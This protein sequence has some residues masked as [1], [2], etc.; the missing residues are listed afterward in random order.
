MAPA[1]KLLYSTST[2]LFCSAFILV[3]WVIYRLA[4]YPRFLSP[5]RHLP[6][7]P[8]G[9]PIL[10]T[11][12]AMLRAKPGE[13]QKQ[14]VN[15]YGPVIRAVGPVGVERM[16][17]IKP[18]ALHK[19]LVSGWLDYPRVRSLFHLLVIVSLNE[20]YSRTLCGTSSE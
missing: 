9:D 20:V 6:G 14:W 16:I 11:I 19:I 13:L 17:F 2:L 5:L 3:V 12:P 7:P 10:G 8:L 4:I 15:D 18:D 1:I